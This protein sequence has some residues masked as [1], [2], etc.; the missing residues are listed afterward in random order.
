MRSPPTLPPPQNLKRA[1][2]A[3]LSERVLQREPGAVGQVPTVGCHPGGLRMH[4]LLNGLN[5]VYLLLDEN[6]V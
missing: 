6:K 4:L 2:A 5:W 3:M 1:P